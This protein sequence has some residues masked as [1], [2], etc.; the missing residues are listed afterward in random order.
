M[1]ES[2]N[3]MRR[4]DPASGFG[5]AKAKADFPMPNVSPSRRSTPTQQPHFEP[6]VARNIEARA[7]SAKKRDL[8]RK[9]RWRTPSRASRAA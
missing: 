1:W 3:L 4:H 6:V 5:F 9:K 8:A 7:A 2:P